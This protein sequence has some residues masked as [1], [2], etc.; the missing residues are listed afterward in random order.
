MIH[1][2]MSRLVEELGAYLDLRAPTTTS[3]RVFAGSLLDLSGAPNKNASGHVVLSVVNVDENR[4]YH[5]VDQYRKRPDGVSERMRPPI[6]L[7]VVLLVVANISD[8]AEALKM[9]SFAISFFQQRGGVDVKTAE[10]E[11]AKVQFEL[12]STTFEQQNHLWAAL[13]AKYMPSVL[14]KAGI[15]DI[16]DAQVESEVPPV[17]EIRTEA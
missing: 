6:K 15:L 9:L 16:R 8:Y 4:V 7:D 12:L 14:Y 5:S 2:M 1:L 13:G 11:R 3:G 17:E 10:G